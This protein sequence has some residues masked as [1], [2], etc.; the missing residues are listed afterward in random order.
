[1]IQIMF[2]Q[3]IKQLVYC[4]CNKTFV[5]QLFTFVEKYE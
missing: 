5:N 2:K 1:M 3:K 4:I